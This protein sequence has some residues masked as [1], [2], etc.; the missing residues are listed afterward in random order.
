MGCIN[1]IPHTED[2]SVIDN[3]T[4]NDCQEEDDFISGFMYVRNME[5]CLKASKYIENLCFILATYQPEQIITVK[6]NASKISSMLGK[7]P[8]GNEFQELVSHIDDVG[9]FYLICMQCIRKHAA[10]NTVSTFNNVAKYIKI[11]II[12]G[13][14]NNN[15]K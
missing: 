2:F 10:Q 4:Y 15:T 6:L 9:Q 7:T 12:H 13:V 11:S 3:K 14:N 1:S 5:W 8:A